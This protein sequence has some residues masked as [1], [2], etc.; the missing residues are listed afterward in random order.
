[1]FK[2]LYVLS[3]VKGLNGGA[4]KNDIWT[5]GSVRGNIVSK[6]V[7]HYFSK[8]CVYVLYILPVF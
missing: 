5:L 1:M 7:R 4:R 8:F 3:A 6:L 2:A